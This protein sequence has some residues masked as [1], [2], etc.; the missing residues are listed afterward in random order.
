MIKDPILITGCARSG[1][2]MTAGIINICGAWGGEMSGQNKFNKKGMFENTALRQ[3]VIK[4]FLRSIGVDPLGQY[5][6]PDIF[7]LPKVSDWRDQIL[8]PLVIQ[9]LK[10]DFTWFYKCAKAC[11]IWPIWK[12]AFPKAK[13]IIVR[14]RES[15]IVESCLKTTF[16]RAFD[17]YDGWKWWTDQHLLRFGEM[18]HSGLNIR[19]VWPR[20]IIEGDLSEIKDV[21]NWLELSWSEDKIIDFV[22][23][24]LWHNR[25]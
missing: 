2:S 25:G 7:K 12:E 21:I 6:L 16:M 13:W 8:T 15:E 3:L 5:P 19:E 24:S 23:P 18:W 10:D 9:G 1:T 20:K 22:S 4:P 11:L 14:R 17:N